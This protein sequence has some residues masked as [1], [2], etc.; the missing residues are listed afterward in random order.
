MIIHCETCGKEKKI[1]PWQARRG[2]KYC[3]KSCSD[4]GRSKKITLTC[5]CCGESFSVRPYRKNLARFCSYSCRARVFLG[6]GED[7]LAYKHGKYCG[8]IHG[9]DLKKLRINMGNA[10]QICGYNEFPQVLEIHHVNINDRDQQ[11]KNLLLVCP[12]CHVVRQRNLK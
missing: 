12:T 6:T 10:C 1:E 4:K 2:A 11:K 9:R 3:S 7:N 8:R 5:E